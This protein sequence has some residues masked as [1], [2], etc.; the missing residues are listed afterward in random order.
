[1]KDEN[2]INNIKFI[3]SKFIDNKLMRG[4]PVRKKKDFEF[5]YVPMGADQR[6]PSFKR[7]NRNEKREESS[8]IRK[9]G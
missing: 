5:D 2:N 9:K 1:V 7:K 6:G 3:D 8:I 4:E